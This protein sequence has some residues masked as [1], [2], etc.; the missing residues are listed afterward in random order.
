MS[1]TLASFTDSKSTCISSPSVHKEV[2]SIIEVMDADFCH[3]VQRLSINLTCLPSRLPATSTFKRLSPTCVMHEQNHE[4]EKPLKLDT[5]DV[6]ASTTKDETDEMKR[7]IR[8][9]Q[10]CLLLIR[11]SSQCNA[12]N[13]IVAS[14]CS[15]GKQLVKHVTTCRKDD[16]NYP[17]CGLATYSI[18]HYKR[19]RAPMK[20]RICGPVKTKTR[21]RSKTQPLTRIQENLLWAWRQPFCIAHT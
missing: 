15:M 20:C 4:T 5:T 1:W 7:F 18:S 21:K 9:A 2:L 12:I 6:E 17:F 16:C 13:C 10:S 3:Q 14:N 19:C 8:N 11:H